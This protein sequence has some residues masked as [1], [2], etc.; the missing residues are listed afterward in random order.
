MDN[1][2]RKNGEILE[3]G[4]VMTNKKSI[5]SIVL[6]AFLFL[7]FVKCNLEDTDGV[8]NFDWELH[9]TWSTHDSESTYFGTLV[10]DH[11]RITI[12]GYSENQT[13]ITILGGNDAERPFRN[14]IKDTA[15]L[16]YSE[17]GKIFIQDAGI[18]Q[19]GIPYT[20]WYDN[21]PPDYKRIEFLRFYFANRPETLRKQ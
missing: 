7:L 9:G 16:G 13:P 14:F 1:A 18:V 19:E 4:T 2:I 8:G 21:P 12:T 3:R 6:L 11:N 17:E 20:Y 15:L 10:I 5:F